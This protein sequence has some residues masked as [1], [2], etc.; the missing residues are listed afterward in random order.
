MFFQSVIILAMICFTS[1]NVEC[2]NKYRMIVDVEDAEIVPAKP[3]EVNYDINDLFRKE[4][5]NLQEYDLQVRKHGKVMS[6]AYSMPEHCRSM[7]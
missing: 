6:K 4:A 5:I 3:L 2:T 7:Y 1:I